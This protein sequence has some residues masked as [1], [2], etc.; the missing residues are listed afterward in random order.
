MSEHEY[1]QKLSDK[2]G[3][4]YQ[5]LINPLQDCMETGRVPEIN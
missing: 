5:T 3:V 2:K 4:P 1:F